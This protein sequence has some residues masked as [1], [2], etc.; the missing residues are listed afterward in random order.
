MGVAAA[1]LAAAA[2]VGGQPSLPPKLRKVGIVGVTAAMGGR[3]AL[4]FLGRTDA[5]S[6]GSTSERFRVLDRRVFSPLCVALAVGSA[7]ALAD[8]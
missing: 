4:G 8:G 2:L 6:P 3:G 1:L 7:A 5:V